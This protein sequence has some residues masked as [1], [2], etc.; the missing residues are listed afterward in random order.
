MCNKLRILV[1]ENLRSDSVDFHTKT[2]ASAHNIKPSEVT[3]EQR[4]NAKAFN[5]GR[6][7][8][9]SPEDLLVIMGLGEK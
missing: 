3:P 4:R 8:S 7:Y 2:A 1:S 6:F 5:Y 9:M